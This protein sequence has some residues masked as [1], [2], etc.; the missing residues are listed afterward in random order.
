MLARLPSPHSFSLFIVL[1]S[2]LFRFRSFVVVLFS[3][4]LLSP[5]S[6]MLFVRDDVPPTLAFF[7]FALLSFI[8][9]CFYCV[10]SLSSL[11]RALISFSDL[12]RCSNGLP[13]T[14]PF[15]L[16]LTLPAVSFCAS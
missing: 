4:V 16:S 14:K 9:F 13:Y 3:F 1:S 11:H 5:C 2:F 15:V 6:D 8:R 7:G 12:I 10:L